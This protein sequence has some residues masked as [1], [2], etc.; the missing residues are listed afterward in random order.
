VRLADGTTG[1]VSGSA[2][3]ISPV[4]TPAVTQTTTKAATTTTTTAATTA[5][6]TLGAGPNVVTVGVKVHTKPSLRAT[7]ETVLP[8]GTHVTVL[9]ER[10]NWKLVRLAT[11]TTGYIY[12]SY[13]R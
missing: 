13:V 1:W 9:G 11:G 12:A 2:L 4:T 6:K 3:G 8:A 5:R 10:G 7:V